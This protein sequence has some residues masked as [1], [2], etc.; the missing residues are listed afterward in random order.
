MVEFLQKRARVLETIS[1]NRPQH[2]NPKSVNH[3]S[4]PKKSNQP[5]F[6]AN[7]A[8]EI[9]A[10]SFPMC[11]ACER[12]KHS[13]FDCSVFNG[14][15][16]KGRMKVVTD[17]KLCSNCFRSDHFARNCRSKYSCKH[18]SKRH[19][20]MIH[21]GPYELNLPTTD[22]NAVSGLANPGS[23]TM[24]AAVSAVPVNEPPSSMAVAQST[25][26]LLTTVVLL[27]VD[28]YGQEHIARV[29][30]DTGS[31][32]NAISERLCQQLHLN[33]RSVN[34][35]IAG[36]D[37]TVTNAKHEVTAEVR[38]RVSD[39][40]EVIDFLVL[41]KVTSDTPSVPFNASELKLPNDLPLADP[42]F[43]TPRRVD[44][45]IGAAHFFSFLRNGRFRLPSL[46]FVETVFG[47]I[48]SGKIDESSGNYQQPIATC[49][50]ATV[51]PVDE[52]LQRFWQIEEV[53]GSNYSVDEQN[54]ED[55]YQQTVSR[56]PTGRYIVRMP[57]H[58]QCD[59]MIGESRAMAMRR[60]QW[61]DK[62]LQ[63]DDEMKAQ[64]Y[65]FMEEYIS[66]GHMVLAPH[67]DN[68]GSTNC[69]LPHHPVVKQSSTTTKVR[70]VFDGSA[71][72]STGHS[73][74]DALLVG[75]VVQDDILD[76]HL[77]FRM[78]KIAVV[79]DAEKM[80]RQVLMHHTD[81]PLQKILWPP[82]SSG[83]V[84]AYE[85]CTVTYGLAP[86]S[87]LAT[88]TL[89]QLAEDHGS[90]YPKASKALRKNVYVDDF[91]TGDNTIDGA[92]QLRTELMQL[93]Q[94]GGFL[95]RKWCSNSL[96]VLDGL[97]P[98]LLGTQSSI[99]FGP[100]E[101]IKTLGISW[102]PKADV[103]KFDTSIIVNNQTPT[104]RNILST[105]AQLFDPL[106]II[107]P[108]VV[109]AKILMQHLWLLALEWDAEVPPEIRQ[110]W[111]RFAEQLPQ[112]ANFR[113]DRYALVPKYRRIELH[114]F[115]DASKA[116]YGACIY[117]R[118]E[119]SDGSVKI[120]LLASKSK[121]APLKPLS[122]PR[123]ELCAALIASRLYDRISKALDIN[124]S[125]VVFWSDSTVVLQWMKSPPR[126]WKTF[127][128]NR[129]SEIQSTTHGSEWLHVAGKDNPADLVSRGMS[130]EELVANNLWKYGPTWL[131]ED[132]SRWPVQLTQEDQLPSEE[133]EANPNVILTTQTLKPTSLFERFSSYPLLLGAV[134]Y[135]FRFYNNT[136]R[137][138]EHRKSSSVL[139]AAELQHSKLALVKLVQA[140]TFPEDLKQL[141]KRQMVSGKSSLRLLNPFL[142]SDGLIRVG[143][144]LR[145]S[146]APYD[147]K[148][149][150]VIP[151]FHPFSQLLLKHQHRKLVHGGITLTLAVVRDEFWPL[152]GR[153]SVRS[154]IRK[155]Y[156]CSRSN[157]QPIQQPIGQLPVA[158]VT[159]NEAF[160][161]TGVDYCGPIFLK[162]IHRRA[163]SRK[164]YI[165][166][167][168]C[169]S[170]KA[171][172]LELVSDLST[173]AFLMALDRFVW[174]RNKPQHLYSDNG[175]NFIG[176][177]NALHELY[178]MLQPGP[179]N[180]KISK[181]L[182]ED[183]IQWHLIPPR[184]PNFGGLWEAAVKVAK[185]HLVRQLG[186][187]LLS[188]EE[189]S[190]VLTKIE[191]CMNSRPLL[192]L[193]SDPNDFAAL[194][195]AHF[196]VKNM[197]RPIPEAD[198]RDVPFN[199]LN[200]YQKLQKYAQTFWHRWR[201]E[202]LKELNL[203]Y[204]ANP[205]RYQIN[206][207]DIVIVKD[208]SLP[209]A[210]WPLARI[211]ELHTGLDGVTRVVTVR[212]PTG[213]FKRAVC[214]ICPLEC[215]TE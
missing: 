9:V 187:S 21:P 50:V 72:T 92:I 99:K 15:D 8:T 139:S 48:A 150:I 56:D 69:Y 90:E 37:G 73:L 40:R 25:S 202:Y 173:A 65:A 58:P 11:P 155:C 60:L 85:L 149:Q 214:K 86:S 19:H 66:L 146:D 63:K 14:L 36:V 211:T 142:D 207:G 179:D 3:P 20:S 80:Y 83:T 151:G 160:V 34:V 166:V 47:W 126:S 32:P 55:F 131:Q 28:A 78:V 98:E 169:L 76:I 129:I 133:M 177:K 88:R 158:R 46:L 75:P 120:S 79:A 33:R 61:L 197:I 132:I 113:I 143:G 200:Q 190:T 17:K 1:I 210:R 74:N 144:R 199:R 35:P 2:V 170:T 194:T 182:A 12:Q 168:V 135:C 107:S 112:L 165:C 95:L 161:C 156:E 116:A 84:Q 23:S 87:F 209:P 171:V 125:V 193:S 49:H 189:F 195:P 104:K 51:V 136:R 215:S 7:A 106:G 5:R 175:T 122:I 108:V 94:K 178:A 213:I 105:I 93:L 64:Y 204:N 42:D 196:L 13:I 118:S 208:E 154:A 180:D 147:V 184:A 140:E 124:F 6:S 97:P 152:N 191:G 111:V 43:G 114:C 127:V 102:E 62:R 128:A 181:H 24:L 117:V 145:L 137:N 157:P 205:K 185:T 130:A 109:Q 16:S 134:A 110:Q 212:T 103:F 159:A 39:F 141:K 57:K 153:K 138:K 10:K 183:S 89:L 148:H 121:V 119:S 38:S 163:A 68:N 164:S 81:R 45:I 26:V 203:Q 27:V 188:I 29:L 59:Q 192:P 176:A 67:D 167:F 115:A 54:C 174:R 44:M 52:L 186:S 91:I 53:N 71:K 22:E 31:Q 18:C 96:Q 101:T 123:L 77:R 4:A 41:R 70:V 206:V 30:L 82:S 172:H 198:V 162:P 100:E 201:N